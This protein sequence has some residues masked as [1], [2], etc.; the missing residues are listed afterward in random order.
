MKKAH[1]YFSF[2]ALFLLLSSLEAQ[3]VYCSRYRVPTPENQLA[4]DDF[5]SDSVDIIHTHI[6]LA[7]PDVANRYT[8][9]FSE[10]T[11]LAKTEDVHEIRLDFEGLTVD[12]VTGMAGVSFT[13]DAAHLFLGLPSELSTQVE[14][15][16]RIYYHGEPITDGSGWGGFYF[17]GGFI[18]NLGVGFESDP[19]SYGRVW[20]PC[21]DN[22][23]E[24][25]T[26]SFAIHTPEDKFAACNGTMQDSTLGQNGRNTFEWSLTDPIPS[27]LVCVAIGS[28]EVLES[29]YVSTETGLNTPVQ[30]FVRASD[31][32]NLSASFTHLHDAIEAFEVMYG[33]YK[34]EKVGYS[35]VPFN[36]GAME[37][38]TNITY[39][40]YAANG[41]LSQESLM[42]H[43]LAHM[44]WGDNV[45]CETDGDMWINEGWASFSEYLFDEYVHGRDAYEAHMLDDLKY[46][47]QF[48]HVAEGGY[49]PVSGQPHELVY[50]D[51]VYKKGALVAHNLRGHMGDAHFKN[52]IHAFMDHFT[53][54]PVSS[55]SIERFFSNHSGMELGNFFRDWVYQGGWNVVV[56]DS[57]RTTSAGGVYQT[58]LFVQQ[59]LKGRSAFHDDTRVYYT[60]Y[61]ADGQQETG[62]FMMSGQYAEQEI[63]T[64]IEPVW[65]VLNEG[66]QMAWAQ[67]GSQQEVANGSNLD[68]SLANWNVSLNN[69]ADDAWLR[70]DQI[71]SYPDPLKDWSTKAYRLNQER[72]WKVSGLEVNELDLSAT[73]FYDG[74]E[75]SSTGRPDGMLF[76]HNNEDSLVLLHRET[77][78][79]DWEPY[80]YASINNLGNPD[81]GFGT[82][83]LDEVKAGEYT[84]AVIDHAVLETGFLEQPKNIKLY[85]NPT[86]GRITVE[87]RS[88]RGTSLDVYDLNGSALASYPLTGA[89]SE[90]DMKAFSS[91]IYVCRIKDAQGNALH[92]QRVVISP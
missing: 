72:Y 47:L 20:F 82:I 74:R 27:Y 1:I 19:H 73:F 53:F 11:F 79:Q 35:L 89:R 50:G 57:F 40:I 45:T 68:F 77:S 13:Q 52:A 90:L 37:H 33:D 22:F 81:D 85:P 76:T 17:Q 69:A 54:Q 55:D 36:A 29:T 65:I 78:A 32:A 61:D 6:D 43:E 41:G 49:L 4:I 30:L 18:W 46:M 34:F 58:S 7:F 91:G 75:N 10:L 63:S 80:E 92:E 31:S 26:Y 28:Y 21:F 71:W 23:I 3:E 84:L 64:S 70:I 83:E 62:A 42:A 51:H 14:T 56:L 59:K 15:N 66:N 38:A 67:T 60:A 86:D 87:Q 16:L 8:E 9:G 48:G 44:W 12:S 5:R 88:S 24:R 25:S 2:I 39:P